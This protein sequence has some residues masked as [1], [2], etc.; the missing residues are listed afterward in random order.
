MKLKAFLLFFF[1][2]TIHCYAQNSVSGFVGRNIGP[3]QGITAS[4]TYY[5]QEDS[6]HRMFIG[7][8][9]GIFIIDGNTVEQVTT[10]DGL[11][12]NTV[13][14]LYRDHAGRIWALTYAGGV[15]YYENDEWV[16][17]EWN[18]SVRRKM[19]PSFAYH[20]FVN[21]NDEVLL[22]RF[23]DSTHSIFKMHVSADTF[24][25]IDYPSHDFGRYRNSH[26]FLDDGHV[27]LSHFSLKGHR[28]S[29]YAPIRRVTYPLRSTRYEVAI[30]TLFD[31]AF[32]SMGLE[33]F[34]INFNYITSNQMHVEPSARSVLTDPLSSSDMRLFL[35]SN[36]LYRVS[37]NSDTDSK[38]M[39]E[40]PGLIIN[41]VVHG[42][43]LFV[44]T[45]D[46][47]L[48]IYV[49][50]KHGEVSSHTHCFGTEDINQV[51]KDEGGDY[52]V[53]SLNDGIFQ[54]RSWDIVSSQLD[55]N[56]DMDIERGNI[57]F[58]E[59]TL[60]LMSGKTMY[61]YS[62]DSDSL[63]LAGK[64]VY[65]I[66]Y[67]NNNRFSR[68][69]WLDSM[70]SF[71]SYYNIKLPDGQPELHY[72]ISD[73]TMTHPKGGRLGDLG[74][75]HFLG[76]Q[77][78]YLI[79]RNTLLR[80]DNHTVSAIPTQTEETQFE[81]FTIVNDEL[82]WLSG[83]NGLYI[84]ED[85]ITR[86]AFQDEPL[87][88]IRVQLLGE[89]E[90]NWVAGN[91]KEDGLL[92]FR[93]D[94]LFNLNEQ[95][96]LPDNVIHYMIT[97]DDRLYVICGSALFVGWFNEDGLAGYRHLPYDYIEGI[98]HATDII[99]HDRGI[100]L[101]DENNLTFLP[102]NYF[103]RGQS[104]VGFDVNYYPDS[105]FQI[106]KEE[107]AVVL[108]R[109]E[110]NL[111]WT[112]KSNRILGG[113]NVLW[114]WRYQGAENW[115]YTKTGEVNQQNLRDGTY[116]LECQFRDE[117]GQ[118]GEVEVLRTFKIRPLLN[119]TWWFWSFILSPVLVLIVV[120]IYNI[121]RQRRLSRALLESNMST[122]KMQINPHF[123]FN[124]FN[125]IQYLITTKKNETASEYLTR[126]ADLIRRTIER[127]D[128]HRISLKEELDYI[129]EFLSIESMRLDGA[130]E[131]TIAVSEE[132][133][134]SI[135]YIPPMLLQPILE[136]SVWHGVSKMESGG[137]V[138]IEIEKSDDTLVIHLKDN[139]GGFPIDRWKV[140]EQ[141]GEI[142]GSL[143]LRNVLRRLEILSEMHEKSYKMSLIE[144]ASGT[145]FVLKLAL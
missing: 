28:A 38:F 123:I 111:S 51:Y 36:N 84:F 145:H 20:I 11:V 14:K 46:N 129:E 125:S 18:E 26:A 144:G 17:P 40:L 56:A 13:F 39:F 64:N 9:Q 130:F 77:L 70:V 8:D 96:V 72:W 135:V 82:K 78:A 87:A 16:V 74:K 108:P 80:I 31:E 102:D 121:I 116:T 114:R 91:T 27:V 105:I 140:L 10:E 98:D 21:E 112:F 41:G 94:T 68:V 143:G 90:H 88:S 101:I 132:I 30:D 2:L 134:Q 44:C 93:D 53:V 117:F 43:T 128:L 133:N 95:N 62:W 42:D 126:L 142:K 69:Q 99:S 137:K 131:Y 138:Q 66:D 81:S 23:S 141:G 29:P 7:T 92:I 47:G 4:D 136:N 67:F 37:A 52:W 5:I 73:S 61:T 19:N 24:E 71:N 12:D 3:E 118:W 35:S 104:Y 97:R 139:G 33:H 54:V 79:S 49:F 119:E 122:L 22:Q 103:D 106:H 113:E 124:S 75:V 1:S 110:N 63:A 89:L 76:S 85:G 109:G 86:K 59:G 15:C 48:H 55:L 83:F 58:Q 50:D 127:P 115:N 107:Q 57:H 100:I 45:Y 120:S 25:L 65:D 60:Y 34:Q 32:E 6:N